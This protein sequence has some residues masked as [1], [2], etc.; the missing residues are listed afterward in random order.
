MSVSKVECTATVRGKGKF[1]IG[2]YRHLAPVTVAALL[3]EFPVASRAMI[4]PGAMVTLLTNIKIG[5][6]KQRLEFSRGDVAFLAANGSICIFLANVKSQRPLNPVGK[7]EEGFE[8]LRSTSS[9]DV[10]E[11]SKVA[12]QEAGEAGVQM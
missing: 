8:I 9:G 5:V 10:V 1:T 7:V 3:D 6:E 4:Y 11:I 12:A 2:L